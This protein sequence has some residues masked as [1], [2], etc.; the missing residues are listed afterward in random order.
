M[1]I[2]IHLKVPS[3]RSF[4]NFLCESLDPLSK[5]ILGSETRPLLELDSVDISGQPGILF[6]RAMEA[7]S[8]GTRP[9]SLA[10]EDL[11][12]GAEITDYPSELVPHQQLVGLEVCGENSMVPSRAPKPE[13]ADND[14]RE[15]APKPASC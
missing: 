11:L 10:L 5:P 6:S 4:G 12:L 7:R 3:R 1:A 15:R 14:P 2:S 13:L 8:L 9:G